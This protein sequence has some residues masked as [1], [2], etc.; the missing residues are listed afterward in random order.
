MEAYLHCFFSSPRIGANHQ[1]E[2]CPA[3]LRS[4][5]PRVLPTSSNPYL[6][7]AFDLITRVRD[8]SNPC[9]LFSILIF[10]PH[11]RL[12]LQDAIQRCSF[13]CIYHFI[14]LR[15]KDDEQI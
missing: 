2:R 15:R 7:L 14:H 3:I 13:Q 6:R 8:L 10:L 4:S 1:L 12:L 5:S 9:L 11:V